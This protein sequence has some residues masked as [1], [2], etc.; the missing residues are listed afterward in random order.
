MSFLVQ[1]TQYCGLRPWPWESGPPTLCCIWNIQLEYI[2]GNGFP[3]WHMSSSYYNCNF[4][5]T[6]AK[7]LVE[8]FFMAKAVCQSRSYLLGSLTGRRAAPGLWFIDRVSLCCGPSF[9]RAYFPL[10]KA[11]HLQIG[12]EDG[13]W[14]RFLKFAESLPIHEPLKKKIFQ[15]WGWIQGLVFTKPAFALLLFQELT[16]WTI[17][18]ATNQYIGNAGWLW[19]LLRVCS[20]TCW[21]GTC[22]ES[23]VAGKSCCA[24]LVPLSGSQDWAEETETP[25]S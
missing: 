8:A 20:A 1:G 7:R 6:G 2:L 4:T 12:L 21:K 19:N 14:V 9:C 16:P 15:C 10:W 22:Q 17:W 11:K 23:W 24:D 5:D 3:A 13:M 25:K 18:E